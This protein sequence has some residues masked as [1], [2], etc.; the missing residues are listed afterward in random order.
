MWETVN[1]NPS[2]KSTAI[3]A[4]TSLINANGPTYPAR[5]PAELLNALLQELGDDP[6]VGAL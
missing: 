3:H 1:M 4:I 2:S 5:H 6:L